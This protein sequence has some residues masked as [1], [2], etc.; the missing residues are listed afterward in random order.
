MADDDDKKTRTVTFTE[1]QEDAFAYALHKTRE[2][3]ESLQEVGVPTREFALGL[4]KL[5]EAE[6]WIDRGFELL[7]VDPYGDDDEDEDDEDEDD[8]DNDTPKNKGK[9]DE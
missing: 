3:T 9:V 6:M 5:Q 7:D 8:D 1:D 4:T 2:L